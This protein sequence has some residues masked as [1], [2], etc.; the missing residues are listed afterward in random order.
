MQKEATL[1]YWDN[2]HQQS[3]NDGATVEWI[4]E[5]NDAL[6]DAI[7]EQMPE[8]A[9]RILEIGCGTS[10][11]CEL[12]WKRLV[13]SERLVD[14]VKFLVTDVSAVCIEQQRR[15]RPCHEAIEYQTLDATKPHE[16]FRGRFDM[17]LDK[18]CLDTF[19][20]RSKRSKVDTILQYIHS[21]LKEGSIYCILT[22][23]KKLLRDC[24]FE[25]FHVTRV[26]MDDRIFPAGSLVG[27]NG[28]RI[29]K[30]F[31]YVCRKVDSLPR[32][33]ATSLT[34]PCPACGITL[35]DYRERTDDNWVRKF[36]GHKQHCKGET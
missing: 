1:Q 26:K 13:H 2:I 9:N 33:V 27:A 12:L 21:W 11:L 17:V 28:K 30:Q 25:G 20:F 14:K 32:Q 31:M 5:P 7:L 10:S 29:R 36:L 22:P 6:M 24:N 3:S 23:R 34:E 18:G 15:K 19:L 16:E 35:D 8:Y 4:L